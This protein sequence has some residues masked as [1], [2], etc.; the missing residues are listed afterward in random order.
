[1][2]RAVA[3]S[4]MM[5]FSWTLTAPLLTLDAEANHCACCCCRNSKHRCMCR[6]HRKAQQAGNQK[7]FTTVTEKCP[8]PPTSACT[9]NTPAYKPEAAERFYAVVVFHPARA[10]R[11][12]AFSRISFLRSHPKRGPPVS[13]A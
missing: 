7:G 13:L 12:E 8:C 6:T 2:R 10:P 4:L 1:M 11:S 5:L 9:V 3:I